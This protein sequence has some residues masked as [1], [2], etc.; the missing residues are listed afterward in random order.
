M[1]EVRAWA[2]PIRAPNG[3]AA[4]GL[5]IAVFIHIQDG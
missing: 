3:A 1:F 4:M 5:C 2:H